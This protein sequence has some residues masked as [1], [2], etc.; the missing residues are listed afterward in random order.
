MSKLWSKVQDKLGYNY[1]RIDWLS[2]K[3]CPGIRSLV[4]PPQI[5]IRTCPA[6]GEEVEFFSGDT[7]VK[8]DECGRMLHREASPSCV[9]WCQYAEKCIFDLEKRGLIPPSRV[10]ELLKATKNV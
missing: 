8:C 6:C 2:I 7:E 4:G 5:T 10:K 9:T 3:H 1:W